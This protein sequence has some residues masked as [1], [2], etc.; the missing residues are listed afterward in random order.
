MARRVHDLQGQAAHAEG[1]TVLQ[2]KVR[3]GVRCHS[4]EAFEPL[5]HLLTLLRHLHILR[6]LTLPVEQLTLLLRVDHDLG[7]R[8]LA[9]LV[10]AA[11]VIEV[12]MAE[13]DVAHL[14]LR[15]LTQV[16]QPRPDRLLVAEAAVDEGA[17]AAVGHQIHVRGEGAGEERD[18][19]GDRV[20]ARR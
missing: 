3:R 2:E 4:A 5:E 17:L 8:R 15:P 9:K 14:D 12:V 18:L 10:G 11:G 7:A 1:L 20:D 16:L 19:G 6:Y 13:D